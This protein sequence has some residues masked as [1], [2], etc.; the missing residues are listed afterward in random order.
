[1]L[2]KIYEEINPQH[3]GHLIAFYS[4]L[5]IHNIEEEFIIKL[6]LQTIDK[7]MEY[8]KENLTNK[9]SFFLYFLTV[10]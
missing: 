3:F 5:D 1:M 7:F 4:Y 8:K 9:I 6:T 10:V 2:V